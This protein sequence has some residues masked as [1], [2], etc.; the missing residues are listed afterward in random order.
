M[1]NKLMMM[2]KRAKIVRK[3][4]REDSG[5]KFHMCLRAIKTKH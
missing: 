2:M 4:S 5:F 3:N 1:A